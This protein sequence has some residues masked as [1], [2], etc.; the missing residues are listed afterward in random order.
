MFYYTIKDWTIKQTVKENKC[1]QSNKLAKVY[2]RAKENRKINKNKYKY[3]YWFRKYE[4]KR[5]YKYIKES[6]GFV[7]VLMLQW[8]PRLIFQWL[9]SSSLQLP[10]Y[11]ASI[12]SDR[13]LC[14]G[15]Y[16][17]I[18]SITNVNTQMRF[19]MRYLLT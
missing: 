15:G 10:S 18:M 6:G 16:M 19:N 9:C 11:I 7:V 14:R 12:C 5:I 1:I 3:K 8:T 2:G 4:N 13:C 17:N